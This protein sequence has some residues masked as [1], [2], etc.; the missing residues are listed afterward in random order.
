MFHINS[1]S[2]LQHLAFGDLKKTHF[3]TK[4]NF[5]EKNPNFQKFWEI[6]LFQ[7]K[8]GANLLPQPIL[9]KK[10]VLSPKN[11]IFFDKLPKF[12]I[13]E[14]F[15][16]SRRI[17]SRICNH[18]WLAIL[19]KSVFFEKPS[20][21]SKNSLF[22]N[23]LINLTSPLEFDGKY[24]TSNA[25]K[26]FQLFFPKI[27]SIFSEIPKIRTLWGFLVFQTSSEPNLQTLAIGDLKSFK[28]FFQTHLF[29][30]KSP[31]FWLLWGILQFQMN[32]KGNLQ[33]LAFGDLKTN[34][35]FWR[36]TSFCEKNANFRK[37]WENLMFQSKSTA[38]VLPQWILTKKSV[39]SP[40]NLIF[41][42]NSQNSQYLRNFTLRDE[43]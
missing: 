36:K 13:F 28:F 31:N 17:L 22:F 11:L 6:L 43:F 27:L 16:I 42:T 19:T 25:I 10:S 1:W 18:W 20:V 14:E 38:N 30:Q 39:L 24:A 4:K 2:T 8:S 15:Y 40:K 9:T 23:S 21:S 7:S 26:Q 35:F 5:C 33:H 32:A 29:F 41:L 12:A 34:S 37:F 3:F